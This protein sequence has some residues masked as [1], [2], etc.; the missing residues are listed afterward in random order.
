MAASSTG[1][2]SSSFAITIT[3]AASMPTSQPTPRWYRS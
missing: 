1:G 2:A 3:G